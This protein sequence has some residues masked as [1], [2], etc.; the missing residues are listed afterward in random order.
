M[1]L[2]ITLWFCLTLVRKATQEKIT[3]AVDDVGMQQWMDNFW[4]GC[5]KWEIC[6]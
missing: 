2:K 4:I 6:S 5:Y 3:I 1:Q